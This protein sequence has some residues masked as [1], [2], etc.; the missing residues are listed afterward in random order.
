MI[1]QPELGNR[2]LS[3]R[4]EKGMTQHE[5]REKSHVSVRTIQRIETGSVMPRA[6]TLKILI[7][8]LGD[9]NQEWFTANSSKG[10]MERAKEFLLI[11]PDDNLLR[12]SILYAGIAGVVFLLMSLLDLGM[13]FLSD[14]YKENAS[15]GMSVTLKV[16]MIISFFWFTRG[17]LALAKLFENKLLQTSSYLYMVVFAFVMIL[18][19]IALLFFPDYESVLSLV[20]SFSVI[21]IGSIAVIFGIGL[22]R[23]QDGL[24]RVSRI[25]GK[26]EIVYGVSYMSLILSFVGVILLFPMIVIEIVLLFKADELFKE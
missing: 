5:L 13:G 9:T 10:I 14:A 12:R 18:E 11:D 19:I 15:I 1:D 20:N 23:L 24:G 17:F 6:S 21:A 3:L 22:I 7:D 8:A 2:L 4:K 25:A 16:F 26:I